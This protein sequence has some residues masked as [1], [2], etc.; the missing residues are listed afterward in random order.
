M[1]QTLGLIT[2]PDN[3]RWKDRRGHVGREFEQWRD[4]DGGQHFAEQATSYGRPV[5]LVCEDAFGGY[6]DFFTKTQVDNIL[7]L[8]ATGGKIALSLTGFSAYVVFKAAPV[9]E[10]VYGFLDEITVAECEL[11]TGEIQLITVSYP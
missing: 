4:L 1:P 10:P 7:A 3:I 2:L 11:F 5:T 8:A 9:F 6:N